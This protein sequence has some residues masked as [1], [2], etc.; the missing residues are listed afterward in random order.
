MESRRGRRMMGEKQQRGRIDNWSGRVRRRGRERARKGEEEEQRPDAARVASW[1]QSFAAVQSRTG[2]PE[3]LDLEASALPLA[4]ACW[5][6]L[7][8]L[9]A[10]RAAGSDRAQPLPPWQ[11]TP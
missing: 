4:A 1:A 10:W 2:L 7:A 8:A 6:V 11:V 3:L 5:D 9:L